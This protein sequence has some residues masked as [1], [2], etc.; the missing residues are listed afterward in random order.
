MIINFKNL[1][2]AINFYDA[3]TKPFIIIFLKS[4]ED[5]KHLLDVTR[6]NKIHNYWSLIIFTMKL[7]HSIMNICLHPKENYLNVLYNA[8]IWILCNKNN[9]TVISEWYSLYKDKIEVIKLATWSKEN[10]LVFLNP[11]NLFKRRKSL[12]GISLR[13]T[14]LKVR[15]QSVCNIRNY[16][17]L[18]LVLM[19]YQMKVFKLKF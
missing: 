2:K 16:Y 3:F 15:K 5:F 1:V 9:A 4:L 6:Q 12:K 11:I 14:D 18:I 13:A 19:K 17:N 10:R 8:K 7:D